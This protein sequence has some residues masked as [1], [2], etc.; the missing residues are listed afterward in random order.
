L[1]R[2]VLRR[3]FLIRVRVGRIVVS[4]LNSK[5]DTVW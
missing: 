4:F 2:A 1:G 3:L 5:G